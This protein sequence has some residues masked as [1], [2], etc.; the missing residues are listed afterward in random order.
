[1]VTADLMTMKKSCGEWQEDC[2]W[3]SRRIVAVIG[4]NITL[5][6]AVKF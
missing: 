4:S 3:V 5:K 6:V 2:V 1:M